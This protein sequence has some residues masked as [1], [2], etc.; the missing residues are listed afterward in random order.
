[1]ETDQVTRYLAR[2]GAE[3]PGTPDPAGLASLQSAH[4]RTVPFENLSIHRGERIVLT[5]DALFAKI[6]TAR[7]G[8]FCYELNG[9]FAAL[10][11]ALGYRV[12]LQSCR[13]FRRDGSLGTLF[14]HMTLR[15]DLDHP[16]LV[17]VGFGSFSD[18]PLRLDLRI[19]QADPAGTFLVRESGEFLE[20]LD[21]GE[22][23][24]QIDPRP[25]PL[26]DFVPHCWW[27]ETSPDSHFGRSLTCS[28]RTPTGRI[29]LSGDRLIT[30]GD[31]ARTEQTLPD[32]GAILEA[33]R[34]HFGLVFETVPTLRS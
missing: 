33:Y 22:P 6:V 17:D 12:T 18:H 9:L 26:S 4:L 23:A 24:I 16:Y 14:D 10:L 21:N 3:H 34:H 7:R 31:G 29:T 27:H 1:M 2:I 11:G 15:V 25:Y 30:T 28:L 19:P 13:V 8:G 32:A 20:V 5:E